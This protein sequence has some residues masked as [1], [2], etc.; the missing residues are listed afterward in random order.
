MV[1]KDTPEGT[2]GG[3]QWGVRAK[4]HSRCSYA[5]HCGDVLGGGV[6]EPGVHAEPGEPIHLAVKRRRV[7]SN[8]SEPAELE[9]YV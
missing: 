3:G 6:S 8:R 7:R 4:K 5:L 9:G 1:K 2:E